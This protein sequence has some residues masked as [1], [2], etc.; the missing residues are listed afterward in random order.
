MAGATAGGV[1]IIMH[2][3]SLES[4]GPCIPPDVRSRRRQPYSGRRQ[5]WLRFIMAFEG[6]H[7]NVTAQ[8]YSR[9]GGGG[10]RIHAW[11]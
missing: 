10:I 11:P 2:G 6:R 4:I 9:G 8:R 3:R 5:G 7:H 1:L